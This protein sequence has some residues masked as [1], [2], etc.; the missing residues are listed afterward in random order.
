MQEMKISLLFPYI[1][2]KIVVKTNQNMSPYT[3]GIIIVLQTPPAI[4]EL[5]EY[6]HVHL[7]VYFICEISKFQR[8][9]KK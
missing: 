1:R 4:S 3:R 2:N 9:T 5:S 7:K 8:Q 6:C